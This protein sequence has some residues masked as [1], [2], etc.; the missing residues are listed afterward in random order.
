MLAEWQ[1]TARDGV[2]VAL[3][4]AGDGAGVLV[5]VTLDHSKYHDANLPHRQ[6]WV[7]DPDEIYPGFSPLGILELVA[8]LVA[9]VQSVIIDLGLFADR[10]DAPPVS[11]IG[12]PNVIFADKLDPT[13]Q[14]A[15]V[16]DSQPFPFSGKINVGWFRCNPGGPYVAECTGPTT[17]VTLD[18]SGSMDPDN[19][20]L[21]FDWSGGFVGGSA[22]GQMASV[23][24]PDI[25]TFPV[26]L[27]V[28]DSQ[29]STTCDT[30]VTIMVTPDSIK[31]DVRQFLA[32]GEI[33]NS[34]LADSLLQTLDAAGKAFTGGDCKT[35]GKIYKSFILQL[36]AQSGK[37]VD[38]A[39]AA[40]MI[41]ATQCLVAHCA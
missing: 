10:F 25:G 12:I 32:A 17:T 31:N 13:A 28:A 41:G 33:K 23:Q 29:V 27:K 8:I 38:A 15:D 22:S 4:N 1:I 39:A 3:S 35:A 18:G 34:G 40:K 11:A 21:T 30:K 36:Q 20:P 19:S 2:N 24:F 37:G 26:T 16:D 7:V 5:D 9:P 6:D 14:A